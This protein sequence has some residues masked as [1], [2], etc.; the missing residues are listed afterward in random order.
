[1]P[2]TRIVQQSPLEERSLALKAALT[3]AFKTGLD[4]NYR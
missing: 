2:F 3:R 1:M 4:L